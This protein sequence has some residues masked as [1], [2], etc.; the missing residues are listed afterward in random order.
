[1][2]FVQIKRSMPQSFSVFPPLEALSQTSSHIQEDTHAHMVCFQTS[3]RA[4]G[5]RRSDE[6]SHLLFV[7]VYF[8]PVVFFQWI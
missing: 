1:M 6:A 8:P 3:G 7:K 2:A 4:S 5:G